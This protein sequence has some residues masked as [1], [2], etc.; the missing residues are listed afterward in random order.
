MSVFLMIDSVFTDARLEIKQEEAEDG[1]N[2][3]PPLET[4]EGLDV[5]TPVGDIKRFYGVAMWEELVLSVIS[6]CDDRD[7]LKEALKR[8]YRSFNRW[9]LYFPI[10][11][12]IHISEIELLYNKCKSYYNEC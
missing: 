6:L 12:N 11:G 4:S 5:F 7:A 9:G 2:P 8:N 10:F 1:R 3:C